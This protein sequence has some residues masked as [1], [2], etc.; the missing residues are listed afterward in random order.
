ME[1]TVQIETS[2]KMRS[3]LRRVLSYLYYPAAVVIPFLVG[4]FLLQFG[5]VPT[6]SMEPNYHA[7]SVFIGNRL[8]DGNSL[9][10]GDV[11]IFVH[12]GT[13]LVKR[14]IGL[15]G[16]IVSFE[17]DKVHING[18]ELDESAYL[19]DS[20]KTISHKAEFEVPDGCYFMLGDNR[21][22]SADSRFWDDPFVLS[23]E[24][25]AEMIACFKVPGW[26]VQS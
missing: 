5:I 9:D 25:E 21:T 7:G 20:V 3:S 16:E 11:V 22:N 12:D 2:R 17:N 24:I 23:D 19:D 4:T 18:E 10:R 1:K 13:R 26:N 6:Q 14:V 15:P 8:V